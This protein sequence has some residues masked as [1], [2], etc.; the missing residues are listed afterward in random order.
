MIRAAIFD[1]DETLF[2]MRTKQ[3][4]PSAVEGLRRLEERGVLVILATGRP[5]HSAIAIAEEGIVPDY[6]I[7][8]NGHLTLDRQGKIIEEN[9]FDE[10]LA[11]EIFSYCREH[12]IG[13]LW[14]YPDKVY[15]YIH[16]DIFEVFY[17][18]SEATRKNLVTGRTDIH[19]YRE[20]NGGNLGC[21]L[22]ELEHFNRAFYKRCIGVPID[23][24]SSDLMIWGVNKMSA[25]EALMKKLAI[26]GEEC[27]AFGDNLNDLEMLEYAKVGVCMG[28]GS[29]KLKEKADYVTDRIEENGVWNA[30][31]H[32]E[33]I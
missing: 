22:Q 13:L 29:P 8:S 32:F 33:L 19:R 3:F 25:A 11:E 28:N 4:V 6:T 17:Q 10:A 16:A 2:D 9:S 1:I 30:L 21:S 14:K 18:K 31:K 20:P 23:E 7:C 15:E 27:I 5:P 12:K 24:A 26:S